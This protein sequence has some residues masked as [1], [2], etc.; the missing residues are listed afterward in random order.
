[1]FYPLCLYFFFASLRYLLFRK[2]TTMPN[3]VDFNLYLITDRHQ[4][5]SGHTLLSAV[6]AALQGGVKAVQ[7]RE[8]DLS[9]AELLPLARELRVLTR[10]H[11]ARL[12]IN[13]RIDL[14]LAV[15][16]DG[17]HLG[18]HSLPTD[19]VRKLVGAD[20]LIGISTHTHDEIRATEHQG[21]DFVTFGPVYATPSKAA[22]G[23]PQGLHA[24]SQA[25][26]VSSLPVYALGGIT[27]SRVPEVRQAGA[28]GIALISAI[29]ASS[30]PRTAAEA[31]IAC[32]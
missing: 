10:H 9:A 17:V 21:A 5:A 13:D 28:C 20:L 3:P 12:L 2:R 1:M 16:A 4:V 11:G 30:D 14:A 23:L 25:C 31:F 27:S 26:R 6:E 15:Q 22:F 32:S 8:K 29:L 19:V 24:L 18:G 7:L